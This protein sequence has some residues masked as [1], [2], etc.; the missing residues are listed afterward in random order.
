MELAWI[1]PQSGN[2]FQMVPL[3]LKEVRHFS[4]DQIPMSDHARGREG[5]CSTFRSFLSKFLF[6]GRI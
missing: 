5:A 6:E 2:K 3:A 1:G 4:M